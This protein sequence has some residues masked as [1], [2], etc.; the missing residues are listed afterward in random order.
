MALFVFAVLSYWVLTL[1]FGLVIYLLGMRD[2]DCIGG[3]SFNQD[4]DGFA[5]AFALSW[6]VFTIDRI[7]F[8]VYCDLY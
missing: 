7:L 2:P 3:V 6:Y 5:D 1:I 8:L 4:G